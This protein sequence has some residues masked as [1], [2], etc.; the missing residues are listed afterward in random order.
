MP[1]QHKTSDIAWKTDPTA[2]EQVI[3]TLEAPEVRRLVWEGVMLLDA[4]SAREHAGEP[5]RAVIH[6]GHLAPRDQLLNQCPD[7]SL[8]LVCC[9]NGE[10]RA[11]RLAQRLIR[12]G[13]RHTYVLRGG[14]DRL[15]SQLLD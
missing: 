9:S 12:L 8:P 6:L 13:Y 4:R 3:P 2:T 10:R 15:T 11:R 5:R 7:P 14:L 1:S